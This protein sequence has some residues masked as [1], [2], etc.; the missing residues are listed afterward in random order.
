MCG[1]YGAPHNYRE[2]GR[3][4][5]GRLGIHQLDGVVLPEVDGVRLD[6]LRVPALPCA[7]SDSAAEGCENNQDGGDVYG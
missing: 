2:L 5:A 4:G 1:F 6:G 7:A 3:D